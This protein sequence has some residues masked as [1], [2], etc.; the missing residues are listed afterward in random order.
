MVF[1]KGDA[2]RTVSRRVDGMGLGLVKV[3]VR[4]RPPCC[5]PP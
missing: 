5:L 4:K 1:T 2:G 3:D